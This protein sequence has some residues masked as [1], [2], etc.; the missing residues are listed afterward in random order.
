MCLNAA[1]TGLPD[2]WCC[3]RPGGLSISFA[4]SEWEG[5]ETEKCRCGADT[6]KPLPR[7]CTQGGCPRQKPG[8]GYEIR[9]TG[10]KVVFVWS[11]LRRV[12]T[13][14]PRPTLTSPWHT[15]PRAQ[16]GCARC[17]APEAG[18]ML[19]NGLITSSNLLLITP[20]AVHFFKLPCPAIRG[21]HFIS[22][23]N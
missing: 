20:N 1:C 13:E 10:R 16:P 3:S 11:Q 9:E 14:R 22:S 12:Q 19:C 17:C 15:Q 4:I 8:L 5:K 23:S 18:T 2:L 7:S 6:S 21:L